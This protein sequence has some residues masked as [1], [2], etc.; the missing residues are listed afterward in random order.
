MINRTEKMKFDLET[1]IETNLFEDRSNTARQ[2]QNK[3]D[4]DQVDEI[5]SKVK[6]VNKQLRDHDIFNKTEKIE[7]RVKAI[8]KKLDDLDFDIGENGSSSEDEES[9]AQQQKD[10]EIIELEKQ[11]LDLKRMNRDQ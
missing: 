5:D 10:N 9:I 6:G 3:A 7:F 1:M 4:T 8:E 11:R 2:M